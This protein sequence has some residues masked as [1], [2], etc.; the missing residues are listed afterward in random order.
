MFSIV[1]HCAHLVVSERCIISVAESVI[2][3]G[4]LDQSDLL[5]CLKYYIYELCELMNSQ[6]VDAQRLIALSLELVEKYRPSLL[7]GHSA[8]P[9]QEQ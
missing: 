5:E 1:P 6:L 9:L 8:Q 2:P 4:Y 3:N 7:S